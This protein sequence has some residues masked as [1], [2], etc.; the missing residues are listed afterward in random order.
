[1]KPAQGGAARAAQAAVPARERV[2]ALIR[3]NTAYFAAA[4]ALQGSGTQ[5]VVTLG[6]IIVQR[7]TDSVLLTGIGV[8]I[9]QVSRMLVS[10][11]V[12]KMADTYGRRAAMLAG[13]AMGLVGAPVLAASVFWESFPLFALGA[14]IMGM[15]V[16]AAQQMRVAVTDMFPPSRRGEG[17]GYLLTGSLVGALVGP[18][19][20][21]ASA[22][23]ADGLG[24]DRLALP[25]LLL[26]LTILP[27]MYLVLRVRPDPKEIG[28]TLSRYWAS[29][30]PPPAKAAAAGARPGIAAYLR[31]YPR[32]TGY[33][34]FA[35]AQG[36]M[37]ML[38]ASTPLVLSHHGHPLPAISLAV[39]L[40][41]VGM[42]GFSVPLGRL[43]DR[44]GRRPLIFGGLAVLAAGAAL[45]PLTDTYAVIVAGIFLVGVG[46]SAVFVAVTAL[47]A[48]TTPSHERGRAIGLNDSIGGAFAVSLPLIGGAFAEAWGL[49][50]MGLLGTA[51]AM[52]PLLLLMRLREARPGV[53]AHGA[54]AR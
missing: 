35:V 19:L 39:T 38:M 47:I 6:A 16:G 4:Q 41:I 21:S 48:D 36:V 22:L 34:S 42:F 24:V 29:Y 7:L 33:A 18:V 28:A 32:L 25:W 10:Y 40:H 11:P 49:L 51:I 13:L 23:S 8:S 26:P 52:L 31:S 14:L 37:V 9:L 27:C 12:G 54:S 30:T 53:F 15:G 17:L 2:P 45:V 5:M 46:W 50:S 43:T 20:I 44:V 3:R 1:M